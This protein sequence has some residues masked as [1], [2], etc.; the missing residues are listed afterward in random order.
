MFAH[1]LKHHQLNNLNI[2]RLEVPLVVDY[3]LVPE[4]EMIIV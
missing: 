3:V 1:P 4:R 2:I